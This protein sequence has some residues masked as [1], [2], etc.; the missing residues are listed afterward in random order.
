M[1]RTPGE[2]TKGRRGAGQERGEHAAMTD[3]PTGDEQAPAPPAMSAAPAADL[4]RAAADLLAA[5]GPDSS[6][7]ETARRLLAEIVERARRAEQTLAAE[8][9]RAVRLE[10]YATVDDVTGLLNRRGFED[11]LRR[12]LARARR[13]GEVGALILVDLVCLADVT[14]THGASAGEFMLSAIATML[15]G[16][17]REVDYVARL[18]RGRFAL[19]LPVISQ[20]DARRRAAMLKSQLVRLAVP[21]HG[22]DLAVEV[23]LGLV[24][25]G[26][27]DAVEDL[28]ERVEAELEEREQRIAR[29]RH[30]AV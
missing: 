17:F 10:E 21:W 20:E 14:E 11:G 6:G 8:R 23:R 5:I 28:L 9:E 29:L 22:R 25:Y 12:S 13:Y 26:Q 3:T 15:R 30:P 2:G 24:H 27:R 7:G 19:L 18:E 1:R 4:D 16:R